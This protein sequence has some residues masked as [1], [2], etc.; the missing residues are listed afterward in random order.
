MSALIH[1][2]FPL[3]IVGLLNMK[4]QMKYYVDHELVQSDPSILI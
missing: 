2:F 1:S 3:Q 4:M